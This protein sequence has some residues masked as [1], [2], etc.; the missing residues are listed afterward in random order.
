MRQSRP[1]IIRHGEI[2]AGTCSALDIIGKA[3]IRFKLRR[4]LMICHPSSSAWPWPRWRP[5]PRQHKAAARWRRSDPAGP[6]ILKIA[7]GENRSVDVS[8]RDPAPS[9]SAI[10]KPTRRPAFSGTRCGGMYPPR[11]MKAGG[12]N[13]M[14][15]LSRVVVPA[16]I[17]WRCS[18]GSGAHGRRAM[19]W[20]RN[21]LGR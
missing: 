16:L 21:L 7:C 11:A 17:D 20:R 18:R 5:R 15:Y 13:C 9:R 4:H 19:I 2:S 6:Q 3:Q 10:A 14:V 12:D 1:E 8:P